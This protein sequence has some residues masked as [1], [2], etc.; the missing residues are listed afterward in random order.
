MSIKIRPLIEEDFDD[1]LRLWRGYQ[2]FYGADLKSD[3]KRLFA[4]LLKPQEDGPFALVV[5]QD[6]RL[7]ALTHYLLHKTSWGA[8]PRCYL[9]DLFTDPDARGNGAG[10]A[11]I[12]AVAKD[13]KERG[14]DQT[15]WLTQDF[16][17][18][19]RK[20]YDRVSELTPFIK[21]KY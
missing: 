11:L 21:Y 4:A 20:L 16:N 8:A 17:T 13:A 1:W 7:I 9:N 5:E 3:E 18:T 10:E 14:A 19:A 2:A 6:D 15:Y 12:H